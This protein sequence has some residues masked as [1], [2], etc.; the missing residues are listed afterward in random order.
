MTHDEL[1]II[2]LLSGNKRLPDLEEEI[3]ADDILSIIYVAQMCADHAPPIKT[4]I[5]KSDRICQYIAQYTEHT[6][7]RRWI[8]AEQYLRR[9]PDNFYAHYYYKEYGNYGQ[10]R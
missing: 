9:H 7:K 2:L 1:K 6:L 5:Y 4:D 8:A 10:L 3:F